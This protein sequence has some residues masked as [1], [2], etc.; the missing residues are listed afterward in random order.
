MHWTLLIFKDKISV[1]DPKTDQN[2]FSSQQFEKRRKKKPRTDNEKPKKKLEIQTRF[3]I[4]SF[5]KRLFQM[6]PIFS[7]AKKLNFKILANNLIRNYLMFFFCF[8]ARLTTNKWNSNS[9]IQHNF[10]FRF[11]FSKKSR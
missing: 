8:L 4:E 10:I 11:N 9:K 7:S 3:S 6:L 5:E 1:L 2:F